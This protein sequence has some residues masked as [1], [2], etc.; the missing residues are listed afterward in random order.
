M[1][2]LKSLSIED[3]TDDQRRGAW[4][5][6][7]RAEGYSIAKL[8]YEYCA[9]E[10]EPKLR[11]HRSLGSSESLFHKPGKQLFRRGCREM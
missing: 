4:L 2:S 6:T 10:H 11:V 7:S 1:R 8:N 9:S 3:Q 5:R